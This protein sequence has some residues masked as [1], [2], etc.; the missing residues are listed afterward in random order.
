MKRRAIVASVAFLGLLSRGGSALAGGWMQDPGA[1]Y[2]KLWTRSLL[3]SNVFLASGQNV[4]A[5][6]GYGDHALNFYTEVGLHRRWTLV[7]YGRP[8]GVAVFRGQTAFYTGD[9]NAGARFGLLQGT[10]NLALEGHLGGTPPVGGDNL[11]DPATPAV[12]Y[13]PTVSTLAGDLELQLGRGVGS[14]GWL[15][16]NAGLRAF[17]RSGLDPAVYGSAQFG[18]HFPVGFQFAVTVSTLQP[19]GAVTATNIP[20]T[21]QTRYVGLGVDLS[22]W[23]SP[24]WAVTVG[25][26]TVLMAQSNAATVPLSVGIEHRGL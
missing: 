10:W 17:T 25:A 3:G 9:L 11:G 7:A 12:A 1:F 22:W 26:A 14:G 18:W 6:A 24:R 21:G 5:G 19:L 15:S 8:A 20:G 13:R 16:G 4:P 23:F 2:L